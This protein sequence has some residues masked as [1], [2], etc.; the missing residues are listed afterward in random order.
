MP[1]N[2][3][4][5]AEKKGTSNVNKVRSKDLHNKCRQKAEIYSLVAHL[6]S[7]LPIE[8]INFLERQIVLHKSVVSC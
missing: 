5:I 1:D 6:K 2:P 7:Y 3:Q 8:T 4:K